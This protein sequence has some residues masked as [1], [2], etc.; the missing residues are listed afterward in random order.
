MHDILTPR[1]SLQHALVSKKIV[2]R[3]LLAESKLFESSHNKDTWGDSEDLYGCYLEPRNT[4]ELFGTR[5]IHAGTIVSRDHGFEIITARREETASESLFIR[6]HRERLFRIRDVEYEW[7]CGDATILREHE[8][9]HSRTV[10]KVSRRKGIESCNRET[11]VMAANTE[12][13]PL[14]LLTPKQLY[15]LIRVKEGAFF[16]AGGYRNVFYSNNRYHSFSPADHVD[17]GLVTPDI[18]RRLKQGACVLSVGCGHAH[19]ERLLIKLTGLS[20]DSIVL[21][22]LLLEPSL[23]RRGFSTAQ[24][25]MTRQ[26]PDFGR[27][28]DYILFL[29]SFGMALPEKN[30]GNGLQIAAHIIKQAALHLQRGGEIRIIED[31]LDD[32]QRAALVLKLNETKPEFAVSKEKSTIIYNIRGL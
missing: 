23:T 7:R 11:N 29:G 13:R 32:A 3:L 28:F 26:W 17:G 6:H 10:V 21:S 2:P 12:R 22:D 25:D 27:D 20:K 30:Q 16:A 1:Y 5:L 18:L 8:K 15:Y 4:V 9:W 31:G 19:L 14:E 24:F